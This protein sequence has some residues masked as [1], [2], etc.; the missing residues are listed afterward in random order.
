MHLRTT[1]AGNTTVTGKSTVVNTKSDFPFQLIKSSTIPPAP[2]RPESAIDWLPDYLGH[3]WIAYAASSLLVISHFPSPSE[4]ND[5]VITD[6]F[7]RQ[8]F[9]LSSDGSGDVYGV[10]WSPAAIS[11]GELAACLENCIGVFSHNSQG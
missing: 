11:C 2:T 6:P 4:K 5:S 3:A 7:F 1:V 9:E 8:V 10:S